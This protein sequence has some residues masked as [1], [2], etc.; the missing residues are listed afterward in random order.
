MQLIAVAATVEAIAGVMLIVA[1]ALFAR[2]IL[3]SDLNV[4]GETTGRVGGFGLLGL[5]LASWPG[6]GPFSIRGL[7]A[8]NALAALFLIYLG[9]RGTLVGP[10]LWPA[11]ALH[12]ALA[13]LIGRIFVRNFSA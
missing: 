3:N 7:L 5:A 9:I 13:I 6:W 11:A 2:L 1:P 4:G 10:L 8:Y 12:F